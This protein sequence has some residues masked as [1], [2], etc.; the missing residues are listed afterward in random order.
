MN[1]PEK[2]TEPDPASDDP[3][4]RAIQE[5]LNE[6]ARKEFSP[7]VVELWSHPR[8]R[9]TIERPEGYARNRG[10]CGDTMAVYLSLKNDRIVAARYET[11]GCGVT[12]ACGEAIAGLSEGRTL[13]EAFGISPEALIRDLERLPRSHW[14]CALLAVTTLQDA[15]ANYLALG[16]AASPPA[17]RP[18]GRGTRRY[19]Q[20]IE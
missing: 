6:Q 1:E 14:H 15:L 17:P 12:T 5:A 9:G 20:T 18:P 16:G 10:I 8:R 19:E 3:V 11:D 7:R 13:E 4:L 2:R